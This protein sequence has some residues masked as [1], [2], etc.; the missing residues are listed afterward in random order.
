MYQSLILK[1]SKHL[2]WAVCNY[3]RNC[4][5]KTIILEG[6]K[7]LSTSEA[8][9]IIAKGLPDSEKLRMV[10]ELLQLRLCFA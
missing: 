10:Y 3:P 4:L 6:A 9:V 8:M 5:I 2:E 1:C 7:S